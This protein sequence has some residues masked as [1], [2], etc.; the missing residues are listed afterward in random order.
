MTTA[1]RLDLTSGRLAYYEM[2]SQ[3]EQGAP[4]AEYRTLFASHD[5][6]RWQAWLARGEPFQ[7]EGMGPEGWIV[8]YFTARLE[9]IKNKQSR[10]WYA[11]HRADG[12]LRK[13]YLG[14]SVDLTLDHLRA[15]AERIIELPASTNR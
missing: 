1:N 3:N 9:Q 13:L 14:R 11:Y 7:V 15:V 12:K 5:V 10:F 2:T 6:E 8:A 4:V